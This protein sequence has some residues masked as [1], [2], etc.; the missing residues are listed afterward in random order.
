MNDAVDV[1]VVG[2]GLVGLATARALAAQSGLRIALL[3]AEEEV[4]LHQT[5]RNSGVLHTGLYYRPGSL[6]AAYC[7]AGRRKLME[8]A[9]RYGIPVAVRG[10][11]V[12][13]TSEDELPQL[14]ELDRRGHENGLRGLERLEDGEIAGVEPHAAG[15]AALFVPEA[16]VVDFGAVARAVAGEL[17]R[18]GAVVRRGA[19]LLAVRRNGKEM[20]LDTAAGPVRTR[21]LVACA[22]LQADR[23]A[24]LC[25]VDPQVSILPFRGDYFEIVPDRR[26]LVKGLLYPVPDPRFPFLG[27]HFTRRFDDS[28]EVGPNAVLAL[29]RTGYS[30]FA[31]SPR[32]AFAAALTPGLWR[33]LTHHASQAAGELRRAFDSRA[34]LEWAQRLLPSLRASDLRR[35]GCGIRAQAM[36]RDG[37]LLDDFEILET[38]GMVHVL[39]APSP[40]ATASFEIGEEIA[41]RAAAQL[42][43]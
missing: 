14:A 39:N 13:A 7:R 40:A 31:F 3:E 2:G 5:G 29:H 27:V 17:E 32:D 36:R 22:G 33:F 23:V 15:L 26:S 41:R 1:A 25:G 11:L 43:V 9:G 19:R 37:T 16:A 12:V 35:A 42:A 20:V 10:K 30:R 4:A 34:F 28:V 18:G 6:K 8:F 38:E 24:R 21:L